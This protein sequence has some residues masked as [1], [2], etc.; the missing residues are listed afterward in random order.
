M[1][2]EL[3]NDLESGAPSFDD[4]GSDFSE[5]SASVWAEKEPMFGAGERPEPAVA[6]HRGGARQESASLAQPEDL[7]TLDRTER[8]LA[9]V[10]PGNSSPESSEAVEPPSPYDHDDF[11]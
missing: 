6:A 8:S 7:K 9:R 2:I 3:A 10:R 1:D 11:I 5:S 4:F